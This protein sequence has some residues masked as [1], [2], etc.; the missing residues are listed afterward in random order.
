MAGLEIQRLID[1]VTGPRV[2]WFVLWT[3]AA[4]LTISLMILMRTR[5]GQAKPLSKCVILSVFA[6]VLLVGYAY[7]T[8]LFQDV[9]G[10]ADSEA[11]TLAILSPEDDV[12]PGR[13]SCFIKSSTPSFIHTGMLTT[14]NPR[15]PSG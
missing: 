8:E 12:K 2:V 3:G 10:F 14:A 6:H 13:S 9:P 4:A 7:M 11:V 1:M 5:W 15:S